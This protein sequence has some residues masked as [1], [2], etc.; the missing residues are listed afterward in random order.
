MKGPPIWLGRVTSTAVWVDACHLARTCHFWEKTEKAWWQV[1]QQMR[2]RSSAAAR[3][4]HERRP[5]ER[6]V[7]LVV[8]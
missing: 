4:R 5:S 8:R 1:V 3:D 2:F 6:L 7:C